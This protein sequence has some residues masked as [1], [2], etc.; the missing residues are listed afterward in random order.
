M[1]RWAVRASSPDALGCAR[2]APPRCSLCARPRMRSAIRCAKP[3][4]PEVTPRARGA[5]GFALA[6][7]PHALLR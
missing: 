2:Y 3:R 1:A 5:W 7:H 6:A 4:A